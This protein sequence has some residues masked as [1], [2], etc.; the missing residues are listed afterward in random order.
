ME[1]TG[2]GRIDPD[3]RAGIFIGNQRQGIG[4]RG[5]DQFGIDA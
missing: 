1:Q 3:R 5:D 4:H 2:I